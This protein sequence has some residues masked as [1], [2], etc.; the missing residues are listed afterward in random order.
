M[1]S[2]IMDLEDNSPVNL[3][4]S[5]KVYRKLVCSSNPFFNE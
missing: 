4:T 2:Y 5:D 3:F 1:W